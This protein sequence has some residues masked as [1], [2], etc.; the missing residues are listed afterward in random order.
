MGN[1]FQKKQDEVTPEKRRLEA[2][3]MYF[4]EQGFLRYGEATRNRQEERLKINQLDGP[5]EKSDDR[6]V[7]IEANWIASWL[8]FAYYTDSCPAPGAIDNR[9]LLHGDE[10]GVL[11]AK[12]GLICANQT[13][14]GHFRL[15]REQTWDAFAD[16][17]PNSGPKIYVDLKERDRTDKWVI[18]GNP[19]EPDVEEEAS[20]MLDVPSCAEGSTEKPTTELHAQDKKEDA[21]LQ[22][23][24][25]EPILKGQKNQDQA[26]TGMPSASL[27]SS[28]M[29]EHGPSSLTASPEAA[30]ND[31][32]FNQ[33]TPNEGA[34]NAGRHQPEH[35]KVAIDP[36][37]L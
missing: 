1:I 21:I 25:P 16:L 18:E 36:D 33:S 10:A 19:I 30:L 3:R 26:T 29:G 37:D 20:S 4:D 31:R 11:S 24:S 8:A 22:S 12:A 17:Y 32:G 34:V 7:V 35:S 13:R 2:S 27:G 28:P 6:W 5:E 15:I 14:K 23:S 9:V